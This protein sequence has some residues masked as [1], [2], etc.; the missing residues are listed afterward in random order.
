MKTTIKSILSALMLSASITLPSTLMANEA[1]V[2]C[3][4]HN[5]CDV[6][7]QVKQDWIDIQGSMHYGPIVEIKTA[8][9]NDTVK[10]R[11]KFFAFYVDITI[12]ETKKSY[13]PFPIT[14]IVKANLGQGDD[15]YD[16]KAIWTMQIIKGG[17]GNDIIDG[18]IHND[19][20][21]GGAGDDKLVGNSGNDTIYGNA[22]DD[23]IEGGKG[24]DE[25]Y[26]GE[27]NDL[28]AGNDGDDVIYAGEN[29][30]NKNSGGY[31]K[32]G[33]SVL[34]KS[35]SFSIPIGDLVWGCE[36][37]DTIY[38]CDSNCTSG[39]YALGQEGKDT[40]TGSELDDKLDG[41]NGADE[42][43]GLAGADTLK[44]WAGDDYL[45]GG[46]GTD[47]LVGGVG[48]DVFDEINVGNDE[49][50]DLSD[51]A[52]CFRRKSDRAKYRCEESYHLEKY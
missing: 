11:N 14:S 42:L 38:L 39:G 2:T 26:G 45:L 27:D 24:D 25:I 3:S 6:K 21:Y 49:I 10:L 28:I 33:K 34:L 20:I 18:G 1:E 47:Y 30:G 12:N 43:Y 32:C 9:A 4:S 31:E 15:S 36:G 52:T 48:D 35:A 7:V 50:N 13:G 29:S 17:D 41:G 16:G 44:G 40:I 51:D 22:G 19:L 23:D 46:D 8:E 37:N 5:E